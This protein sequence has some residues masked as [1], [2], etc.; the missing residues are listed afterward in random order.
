MSSKTLDALANE[1]RAS[2]HP[3]LAAPRSRRLQPEGSRAGRSLVGG[4][5]GPPP[6]VDWA[7]P[8]HVLRAHLDLFRDRI[9]ILAEPAR[10][11]AAASDQ[12]PRLRWHP[13]PNLRPRAASRAQL[14][15]ISA[16]R[17]PCLHFC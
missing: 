13:S 14:R 15:R 1:I 7:W 9:A 4:E 16:A 10:L 12:C 2:D 11:P 5:V 8:V 6:D 3:R 17:R